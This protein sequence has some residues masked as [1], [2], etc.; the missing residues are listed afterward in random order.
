[1]KKEAEDVLDTIEQDP[2]TKERAL[3]NQALAQKAVQNAISRKR[4]KGFP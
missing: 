1:M 3:K 4:K 2:P